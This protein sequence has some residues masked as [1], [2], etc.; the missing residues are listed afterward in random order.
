M[1]VDHNFQKLNAH[2][3]VINTTAFAANNYDYLN[4]IRPRVLCRKFKS[5]E[6]LYNA[7]D[8]FKNIYFVGSGV[9]KTFKTSSNGLES[10]SGFQM[11]GEWAGLE[12]IGNQNYS[13][14]AQ[15]LIDSDVFVINY[16]LLADVLKTS[17]QA[18]KDFNKT[19]SNEINRN[20]NLANILKNSR[21]ER[22]MIIFLMSIF[23]QNDD[24]IGSDQGFDLNMSRGD[25][26]S[27]LSISREEISR[28]LQKLEI[29]GL[30]FVK[31][32]HIALLNIPKLNAM[33]FD[34]Y[35]LS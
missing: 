35:F 13:N 29:S 32:R 33:C 23:N 1:N 22:K 3:N 9:V 31:N 12:S 5:K 28:I 17:T 6:V 8:S 11:S 10:I 25:I 20:I 27:Y 26:S 7:N 19:L 14:Y 21:R 4:L 18:M 24:H 30:I 34:D 2:S 16:Q 15:A